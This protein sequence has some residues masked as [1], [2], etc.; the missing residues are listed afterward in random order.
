MPIEIKQMK[1]VIHDTI[2]ILP[3]S[4]KPSFSLILENIW[5]RMTF[6]RGRYNEF[7]V[8]YYSI[9]PSFP[10]LLREHFLSSKNGSE[11]EIGLE[12]DIRKIPIQ[13]KVI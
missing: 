1:N 8:K 12:L 11:Q 3:W 13:K 7:L 9:I 6:Y 5:Q 4:A 10:T 2:R